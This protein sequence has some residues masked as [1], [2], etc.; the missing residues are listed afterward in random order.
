MGSLMFRGHGRVNARQVDHTDKRSPLRRLLEDG[1]LDDGMVVVSYAQQWRTL[2]K[3]I[4]QGY[5][6]ESQ[7]LTEKGRA[8][9]AN[10]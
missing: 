9:L 2:S 8:L 7:R 10:G 5:L 6:D 3:A 1:L 4:R